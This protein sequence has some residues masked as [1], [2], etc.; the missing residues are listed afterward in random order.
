MAE[1]GRARDVLAQIDLPHNLLGLTA[2]GRS[3]IDLG[4]KVTAGY[5]RLERP[6]GTS[7]DEGAAG[8]PS[9]RIPGLGSASS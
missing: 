4:G 3:H 5:V 6:L 1:F 7:H 2:P 8:Q 9:E